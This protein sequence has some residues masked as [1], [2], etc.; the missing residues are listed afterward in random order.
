[1]AVLSLTNHVWSV[2]TW[3]LGLMSLESIPPSLLNPPFQCYELP[4]AASCILYFA[5]GSHTEVHY[6]LQIG[7]VIYKSLSMLT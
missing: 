1:M 2:E 5:S 3:P 7:G 6:V 4:Q